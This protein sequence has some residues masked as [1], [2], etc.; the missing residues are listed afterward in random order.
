MGGYCPRPTCAVAK[1]VFEIPIRVERHGQPTVDIWQETLATGHSLPTMPLWWRG[2]ICLAID[3][4][5]TY[6]RTCREQRII[7]NGA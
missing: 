2:A 5:A 1:M 4:D 7:G 6:E 3:L